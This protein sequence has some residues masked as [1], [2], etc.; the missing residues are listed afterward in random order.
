MRKLLDRFAHAYPRIAFL[1]AYGV[2]YIGVGVTWM[3]FP[4]GGRLSGIGWLPWDISEFHA[5]MLWIAAGA[6]ALFVA[7]YAPYYPH[8][9]RWGFAAIQFVALLMTIW[10]IVAWLLA[11][12]PPEGDGNPRAATYVFTYFLVWISSFLVS[13]MRGYREGV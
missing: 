6:F 2:G 7:L 8:M 5:G 10:F 9:E 3:L 4:S 1:A 11:F 13:G 12:I